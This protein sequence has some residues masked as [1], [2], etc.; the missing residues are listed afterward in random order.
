M[1]IAGPKVGL[2]M[3]SGI[4]RFPDQVIGDPMNVLTEVKNVKSLSFTQQLRDY[5]IYAQQNGLTFNL[6]VRPS[7]Q[8]SGPL[9]AA[10]ANKEI[11]VYDI[12]G[13]N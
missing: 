5:A 11:F 12:P 7:T 3:P 9:R 8:M 13:A 1:G 6:Y 2:M 10:I 4:R